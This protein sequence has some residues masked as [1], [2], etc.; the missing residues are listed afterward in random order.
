MG[1][2][3]EYKYIVPCQKKNTILYTM[4]ILHEAK[5]ILRMSIQCLV[6]IMNEHL[7]HARIIKSNPVVGV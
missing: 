5:S 4:V 6:I 3:G 2:A 1:S 7:S